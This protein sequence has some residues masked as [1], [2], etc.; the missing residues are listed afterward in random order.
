MAE[1][2]AAADHRYMQRAL[3]LARTQVGRTGD[4]PSV[5]CVLVKDGVIIG[6]GA[7]DVGG[8]P[9]A[10]VMALNACAAT[11]AKAIVGATAYVTLEPCS[12]TGRSGPCADALIAAGIARCV[13][14]VIDPNPLV[15]GQGA[16]RLQEAGID[17]SLCKD[18]AQEAEAKMIMAD[19]FSRFS[20]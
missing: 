9:H 17:V 15:N 20:S 6:H 2:S 12:H 3:D 5:G 7:T 8:R 13:I 14:A 11:A 10:E 19:F 16:A 1:Q 4:N 18:S